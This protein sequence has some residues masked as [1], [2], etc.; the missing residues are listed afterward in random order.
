MNEQKQIAI[1]CFLTGMIVGLFPFL[2]SNEIPFNL[3]T[4]ISQ[5]IFSAGIFGAIS[6]VVFDIFSKKFGIK[7]GL[8]IAG[9]AGSYAQF[10][11]ALLSLR[12]VESIFKADL[13]LGAAINGVILVVVYGIIKMVKK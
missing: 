8:I 13:F 12:S 10:L 2:N 9:I 1:S 11:F 7:K 6:Y 5:G 3:A 4:F